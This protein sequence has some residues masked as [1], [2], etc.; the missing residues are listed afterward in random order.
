MNTTAKWRLSPETLVA[1]AWR[2]GWPG[3]V[4]GYEPLTGDGRSTARAPSL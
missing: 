3:E 2:S 1:T 4:V